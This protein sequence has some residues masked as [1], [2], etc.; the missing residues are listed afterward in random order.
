M[1]LCTVHL[2]A[3]LTWR[4]SW[5]RRRC[6][7][8][9][10]VRRLLPSLTEPI[11]NQPV[12]TRLIDIYTRI[13]DIYIRYLCDRS[14]A[15]LVRCSH[16]NHITSDILHANARFSIFQ[17]HTPLEQRSL[18]SCTP[19]LTILFSESEFEYSIISLYI[20]YCHRLL[21][22]FD[23]YFRNN[24]LYCARITV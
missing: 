14:G 2:C 12:L 23:A 7:S 1:Y 6:A 8:S 13:V 24:T 22:Y 19:S 5:E 20:E 21:Y 3:G 11:P 16:P 10:N 15:R 9:A 17:S 18:G 4:T